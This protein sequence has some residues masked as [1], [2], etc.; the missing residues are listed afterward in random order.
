MLTR[1]YQSRPIWRP[2]CE[3][4][5]SEDEGL[6][7]SVNGVDDLRLR[8]GPRT[9]GFLLLALFFHLMLVGCATTLPEDYERTYS[10]ALAHPENTALGRFFEDEIEAH[11]GLSG[12]DL[13]KTSEWGFR[14]RV[15]LANMAER[16][17]DVQYY[18]WEVDTIGKI[19]AER[20]L[21]AERPACVQQLHRS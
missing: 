1:S 3:M 9:L 16:T 6:K 11:P 21:R 4:R 18:I 13:V 17:L 7:V 2:M 14:G 15:G 20:L 12:V 10:T 8:N 5:Q 19:L